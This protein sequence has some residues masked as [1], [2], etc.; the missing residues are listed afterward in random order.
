MISLNCSWLEAGQILRGIIVH[1]CSGSIFLR[2]YF[3]GHHWGWDTWIGGSSIWPY[4]SVLMSSCLFHFFL[5]FST[6]QFC[7]SFIRFFTRLTW[8]SEPHHMSLSLSF[9]Q[10]EICNTHKSLFTWLRDISCPGWHAVQK[11]LTY[12]ITSKWSHCCHEVDR[13]FIPWH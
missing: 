12:C 7:P 11:N 3:F 6:L 13:V 10:Y 2:N 4:S 5:F 8:W 9:I 1:T